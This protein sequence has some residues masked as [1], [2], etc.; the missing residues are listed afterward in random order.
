VWAQRSS[1]GSC[2]P[3]RRLPHRL[4]RCQTGP[5][6]DGAWQQKQLDV[7]GEVLERGWA[8]RNQ[9]KLASFT[10]LRPVR[11]LADRAAETRRQPWTGRCASP[12]NRC[13]GL[14]GRW[15]SER[16][17]IREVVLDDGWGDGRSARLAAAFVSGRLDSGVLVIPLVGS[18]AART[19]R[20]LSTLDVVEK[21]LSRGRLVQRWTG[22][23]DEGAWLACRRTGYGQAGERGAGDCRGGEGA[24]HRALGRGRRR[25]T[26]IAG[27]CS[28]TT[29]KACPTSG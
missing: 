17:R 22:L 13:R 19:P 23:G 27:R 9:V 21:E 8:L 26:S 1:G 10:M 3:S 24:R 16:D 28:V 29:R 6:G 4:P 5:V 15:T 7:D 2:E 11:A 25:S 18:F 14:R 12:T 20:P